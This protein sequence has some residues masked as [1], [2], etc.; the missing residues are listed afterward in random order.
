MLV[1]ATIAVPALA[2]LAISVLLLDAIAS[3][4]R[5]P[6]VDWLVYRDTV[7][8]GLAG[9][10]LF[11][12]RQLSGQYVMSDVLATGS[13]YPPPS[14]VVLLPFSLGLPGLVAWLVLSFGLLVSGLWVALRRDLGV[15]APIPVAC[16]ILGLLVF[17]PFANAVITANVN[18]VLAGIYAWS[19]ALG[20]SEPRVGILAALGAAMKV[21]PGVL[22]L[23]PTG[24]ARR[25]SIVMAGL[26]F[27]VL[28]L[29]SVPMVGTGSWVEFVM[30]LANRAPDCV[31]APPSIPCIVGPLLGSATGQLVAIAVSL[32]CLG[33]AIRTRHDR[34]AF[35]LFGAAMMAPVANLHLHYWLFAYV[36]GVV[37]AGGALARLLAPRAAVQSVPAATSERAATAAASSS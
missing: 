28:T 14:V 35:V 15:R 8:R 37:V 30:A 3:V 31:D 26:T 22:V 29:A 17:L 24:K 36:A 27:A 34:L 32:A 7:L 2:L 33:L 4:G 21:V 5:A 13:A 19:W 25:R 16:T 9:L 18:I 12:A 10:S 6:F 11:D 1:G 20:R 23:W